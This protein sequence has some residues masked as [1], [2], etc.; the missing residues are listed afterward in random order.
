MS[1]LCLA[2]LLALSAMN[3]AEPY[4]PQYHFT[5]KAGWLNDPNGLVFYRGEYHLFFQH[6][7]FG[8]QWGNMT[9][10]H[11]VSKD[12]VHWRQ[13][14]N[15]L[16]PDKTGTMYSG[17]AVVDW[18]NTSGFRTAENPPMV[19]LYTAAGGNNEESKGVPFTQGLAYSTDG[20]TFTKFSGNSVLGHIEAENRD[21]K[22]FWHEPSQSWIMA[23]YLNGDRYVLFR[24]PDLK[25][26]TKSGDVAVP[27]DSECP[28]LFELP[29]EGEPG[30]RLWVF[31][32]AA[33]KYRLGEFD[34]HRFTPVTEP[35]DSIF[36]P[37]SYAAQTYS[38]EPKGRRV[39]IGWMRGGDFPGMPFNQQ[40]TLPLELTLRQTPAGPRLAKH[41]VAE[42]LGLRE[43]TL[44]ERKGTKGR[45]SFEPGSDLVEVRLTLPRAGSFRASLGYQTLAYHG[46]KGTLTCLGR[47]VKL[48]GG[49]PSVDVTIY[50]DR[51]S[52]EIFA[53]GGLVDMPFSFVPTAPLDK[54][55]IESDGLDAVAA[56]RL[57][58][59]L[60]GG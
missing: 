15:A 50:R 36:G 53:D 3:P 43:K 22:V 35:L 10:G 20:R 1:L 27:G 32:A 44:L 46:A 6:N 33:G 29:V 11:A 39:Q 40:M 56:Y 2:P 24:S 5:A 23:L 25:T 52:L 55:E 51:T 34:G 16:L 7:P 58:S 4:R 14:E 47:S 30:K 17:S 21:P 26:W 41:P 9:W 54:V 18:K 8:P 42:L 38:D 45:L 12:L 31:W 48:P 37:N 57:R 49:S 13:L 19:M 60:A 28:D 59:A